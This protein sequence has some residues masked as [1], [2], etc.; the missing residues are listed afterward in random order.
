M[1]GPT[2]RRGRSG[3]LPRPAGTRLTSKVRLSLIQSNG[4]DRTSLSR[5]F[6][7]GPAL[8][9]A[10]SAT[11]SSTPLSRS[12]VNASL[13]PSGDQAGKPMRAPAGSA[14]LMLRPAKGRM[15]RLV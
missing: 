8:P 10:A 6:P 15:V 2:G 12:R 11:Q 7:T 1:I 13:L 3:V 4:S 5:T 14:T 9:L